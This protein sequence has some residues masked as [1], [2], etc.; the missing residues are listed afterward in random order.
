M[1]NQP[2]KVNEWSH[3]G[4]APDGKV[5]GGG[6]V[7]TEAGLKVFRGES[8]TCSTCAGDHDF[9]VVCDGYNAEERTVSGTTYH[10]K[11]TKD[12]DAWLERQAYMGVTD[13]FLPRKVA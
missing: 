2:T 5:D 9:I 7:T 1:T 11:N 8:C 3:D 12:L 4:V 10:F 13:K 6:G